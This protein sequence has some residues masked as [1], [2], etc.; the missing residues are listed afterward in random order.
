MSEDRNQHPHHFQ[1]PKFHTV[2]IRKEC[3]A[4]LDNQLY[5][6]PEDGDNMNI[7]KMLITT[8]KITQSHKP[9]SILP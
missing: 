3:Y 5:F 9:Q 2:S 8:Y 6:S 1:N 4:E 7:S